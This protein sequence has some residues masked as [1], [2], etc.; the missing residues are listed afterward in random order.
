MAEFSESSR[1]RSALV[2]AADRFD[3]LARVVKDQQLSETR[4]GQRIALSETYTASPEEAWAR[5]FMTQAIGPAMT[6]FAAPAVPVLLDPRLPAG[7]LG[8]HGFSATPQPAHAV[9]TREATSFRPG[10]DL[11]YSNA[12]PAPAAPRRRRTWIGWLLLGR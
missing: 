1:A 6:T 9:P 12:V 4:S 5:K 11:R 2:D 3:R 8:T 10:G 7:P